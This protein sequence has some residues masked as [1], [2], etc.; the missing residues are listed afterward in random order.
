MEVSLQS[1][2]SLILFAES[3]KQASKF[4]FPKIKNSIQLTPHDR[5]SSQYPLECSTAHQNFTEEVSIIHFTAKN[6][7]VSTFMEPEYLSK[8]GQVLAT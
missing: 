1:H 5:L 3:T 2:A 8:K 4:R 6:L 7:A